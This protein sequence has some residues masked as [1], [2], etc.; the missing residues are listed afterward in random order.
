MKNLSRIYH[1]ELRFRRCRVGI[2]SRNVRARRAFT[3]VELLVVIAI[4]GVLV[5]L[6]LPAVQAAREAARRTQCA[7]NL[8]QLALA[9]HNHHDTFLRFPTPGDTWNGYS[10]QA[11]LL[12]FVEQ[13]NLQD[14]IDFD[15]PLMFGPPNVPT[16]NPAL[17]HVIDMV[18][19]VLIC[20]SDAGEVFYTDHA[21]VRWAGANYMGNSG[22]GTELRYCSTGNRSDGLFWRGSIMRFRDITDGTSHTVLLAETL[23]GRRGEDTV[24]L[25]DARRQM[26][27]PSAGGPCTVPAEAMAPLVATRYEGGRAGQWLRNQTYNSGINAFFPPNSPLP[28]VA[29]HGEALSGARS[30][31][32]G[33]VQIALAD[34]S[35]RFVAETIELNTWRKLHARND[36]QV[37][38]DY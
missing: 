36:G 32:P 28:D 24:E 21:G 2:A 1:A 13:A 16:V 35:V 9:A 33:G 8:K 4:I 38:G 7:N 22:S 18:V 37:I 23:F 10:A 25:V 12:P 20:P 26:K 31:H 27:R 5:A 34:G 14:L 11:Q 17:A 19:A 6:L 29:H 3:L 30:L 15:Q